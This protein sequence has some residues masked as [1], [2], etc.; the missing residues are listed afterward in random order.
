VSRVQLTGDGHRQYLQAV[1]N[2]FGDD[3]DCAMLN[4]MYDPA[5][6]GERR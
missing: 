3:V 2:V 5:P 6:G 1:D 4:K